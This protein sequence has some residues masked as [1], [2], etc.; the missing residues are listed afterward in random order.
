[1][2][3]DVPAL[4]PL[5]QQSSIDWAYRTQ[6]E[7]HSCR[8]RMQGGCA[9]AR[10]K[11]MG[12]SST[13]NYMIYQRGNPKDYDEWEAMGNPGIRF[14]KIRVTGTE[15]HVKFCLKNAPVTKASLMYTFFLLFPDRRIQRLLQESQFPITCNTTK[16]PCGS[17]GRA[18]FSGAHQWT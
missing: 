14:I 18:V 7:K 1:M 16:F 9:W 3:A 13:I 2:I 5:L 12:G 17:G 6:P 8:S 10:G 11:V 4:A 15:I